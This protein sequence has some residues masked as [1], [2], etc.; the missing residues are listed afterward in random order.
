[1]ADLKYLNHIKIREQKGK[2]EKGRK[3]KFE[4]KIQTQANKQKTQN[5]VP[6][7]RQKA[8]VFQNYKI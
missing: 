8:E 4:K 2:K 6:L 1:M 3:K 5:E 7:S